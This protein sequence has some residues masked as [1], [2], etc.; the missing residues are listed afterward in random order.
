MK[1]YDPAE[2]ERESCDN[3]QLAGERDRQ[4]LPKPPNPE[5]EREIGQ[6][7]P[8]RE[9]VPGKYRVTIPVQ[10]DGCACQMV[11]VVIYREELVPENRDARDADADN[12]K[13]A[14]QPAADPRMQS[15]GAAKLRRWH[16]AVRAPS[17]RGYRVTQE[18]PHGT[19]LASGQYADGENG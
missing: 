13:R 5:V 12:K 14:N 17:G 18:P 15:T 2:G 3:K 1:K 16:R 11:V 9:K 10:Q 6:K 4:D 7:L 19:G 8:I